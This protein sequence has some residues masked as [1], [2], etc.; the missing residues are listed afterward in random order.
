MGATAL[1]AGLA[2][3]RATRSERLMVPRILSTSWAAEAL[4]WLIVLCM[5]A[6]GCG[7]SANVEPGPTDTIGGQMVTLT[8][9]LQG[10]FQDDTVLVL[11]NGAQ[12]F[13]KAHIRTLLPLGV[14]DSFTTDVASG[15]VSVQIH[16]ETKNLV[17]TI[18]LDV[19]A[20]TYLGISVENERIDYIVSDDPFG[21][22]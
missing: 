18:S 20:D 22:A 7:G 10:G 11:V 6:A 17:D 12:V 4:H 13:R 14:A 21:Y 2:P 16:V 15:P 5:L 1:G 3:G 9:D 19:S 8:I